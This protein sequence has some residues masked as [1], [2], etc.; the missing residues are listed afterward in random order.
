M[1]INT[2]HFKIAFEAIFIWGNSSFDTVFDFANKNSSRLRCLG[3]A[4]N[5]YIKFKAHSSPC[6]LTFLQ[7]DKQWHG[8]HSL[9]IYEFICHSNRDPSNYFYSCYVKVYYK[10]I[11]DARLPKFTHYLCN[12]EFAKSSQEFCSKSQMLMTYCQYNYCIR[13]KCLMFDKSDS[14]TLV[15]ISL[16]NRHLHR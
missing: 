10:M 5:K 9:W 3:L 11:L 15:F 7:S 14:V 2:C 1:A 6:F 4:I 16:L 8:P 12:Y 13:T